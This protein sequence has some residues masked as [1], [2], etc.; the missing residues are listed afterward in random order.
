MAIQS[1]TIGQT[2]TAALSRGQHPGAEAAPQT[3]SVKVTNKN[4]QSRTASISVRVGTLIYLPMGLKT[5]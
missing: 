1:F 2:L 5:H 3:I 4:G